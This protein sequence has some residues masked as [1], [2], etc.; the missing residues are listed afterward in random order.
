MRFSAVLIL[1]FGIFVSDLSARRLRIIYRGN[2]PNVNL[3][4]NGRRM[5]KIYR[6]EPR[7]VHVERRRARVT[8]SKGHSRYSRRVYVPL[9]RT[10]TVVM[11]RPYFRGAILTLDGRYEWARVYVN[12]RRRGRI[13][14]GR[15]R[16]LRLEPGRV[17]RIQAVRRAFIRGRY[18]VRVSRYGRRAVRRLHF[19]F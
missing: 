8:L 5:G 13:Y 4:V 9:L 15:P 2:I 14:R 10:K 11:R 19:D 16:Y 6:G 7:T 18:R 3:R 1:I 12:G 17:Y